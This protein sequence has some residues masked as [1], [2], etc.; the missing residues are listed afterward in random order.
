MHSSRFG[1]T[2]NIVASTAHRLREHGHDVDVRPIGAIR[3]WDD[4]AQAVLVAASVRYGVYSPRI[5]SF[6]RRNAER[7]ARVPSAFI[8]VNLSAIDAD[9]A[10]PQTNRYTKRFLASTPWRP[11]LVQLFGGELNFPLYNPLDTALLKPILATT[12]R[13]WGP[14]VRVDYTDWEEVDAFA[15]RFADYAA[16]RRAED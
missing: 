2:A 1:H 11:D 9:K 10:T 14:D 12:G 5:V 4:T 8:G 16:S 3:A 15:D 6:T 13:P 7:L